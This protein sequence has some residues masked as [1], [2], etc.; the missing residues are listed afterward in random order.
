MTNSRPRACTGGWDWAP[1][2]NSEQGGAQTF[3]FGIW[4][5]VYLA[6]IAQKTG[7]AITHVVPQIF[8]A[9]PYPTSPLADGAHGGFTV[10]VRVHLTVPGNRPVVGTLAARGGWGGSASERVTLSPGDNGVTLSMTASAAQISLWWP[11][12]AGAQPLYNISVSFSP[13]ASGVTTSPAVEAVRRVGFRVFA[14][15]TGN[16]TDPAYVARAAAEEGTEGFGMFWRVNGAPIMPRGANQIPMEEL[17]GRMSGVAHRRLVQSAVDGGLNTLR[18]WGGGMF[19]PDAWYDA[20]DELGVLVY[21][22][23]QFAQQGHAPANTTSQDAELR[24]AVRRLSAHP[25]IVMW[26]GC[27]ECG[28]KMGT[29]ASTPFGTVS[30]AFPS[31][32]PPPAR[33]LRR[34]LFGGDAG[35]MLIGACDPMS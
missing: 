35:G 33:A 29:R 28:V 22:D 12:G 23:M 4:K 8:Y 21:H 6:R 30:H 15:V 24:H 10:D 31:P 20:C 13:G 32:A 2:S 17:E 25:S 19:L 7:A 34:A 26:D 3:S 1:Y 18:V 11:V 9:G 16:D 14:L 27:N 5:S